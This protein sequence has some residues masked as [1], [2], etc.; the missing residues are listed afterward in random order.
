[1][2]FFAKNFYELSPDELYEILRARSQ[3]FIVELNMHCQDMDGVD[4]NS[5]HLVLRDDDGTVAA[6]MRAFYDKNNTDT[7]VIGRVLTVRHGV[8]IGRRLMEAALADIKENMPCKKISLHSQ[9]RANGFYEKFGFI[10]VSGD[11]IE[12]GVLHTVMEKSI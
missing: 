6:Y 8:G 3:V 2:K 4:Y 12:E 9:K 5:R 11:F 7:V 10:P 1:M